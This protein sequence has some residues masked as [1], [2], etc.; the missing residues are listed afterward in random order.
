MMMSTIK[1][2][3][4]GEIL[5]LEI[6]SEQPPVLPDLSGDDWREIVGMEQFGTDHIYSLH[7]FP[8]PDGGYLYIRT[9]Q[10]LPFAAEIRD[11]EPIAI[12]REWWYYADSECEQAE[13]LQAFDI[14][15]LEALERADE[16]YAGECRI[17]RE[18]QYLP[19]TCNAPQPGFAR[20]DDGKILEFDT[21]DEAQQYCDHY[22]SA[23]SQYDGI[24]ACMVMSHGQCGSDTL[25]IV[26][27][28]E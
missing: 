28:E 26:A 7:Q 18:P 10:G 25:T 23:P 9:D 20:D 16:S 24:R 8:L 27:R 6:G 11:D 15:G 1:L 5:N 14:S 21:R 12:I 19:G 17:W 2:N 22:Y 4:G 3:I 13:W